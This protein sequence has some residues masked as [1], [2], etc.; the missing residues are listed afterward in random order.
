[1]QTANASNAAIICIGVHESVIKSGTAEMISNQALESLNTILSDLHYRTPQSIPYLSRVFVNAA[2]FLRRRSIVIAAVFRKLID[3]S[4]APGHRLTILGQALCVGKRKFSKWINP[5]DR[6]DFPSYRSLIRD[7]CESASTKEFESKM[8]L[9]SLRIP[10][11]HQR[12]YS[13]SE[14]KCV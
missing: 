1:M 9:I 2:K 6:A 13:T 4:L 12:L 3:W 14:L 5:K 7:K 10:T 11:D 8:Y